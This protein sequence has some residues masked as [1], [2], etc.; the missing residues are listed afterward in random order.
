[1]AT[2]GELQDHLGTLAVILWNYGAEFPVPTLDE[3]ADTGSFGFSFSADLPGD[4]LPAP[5]MI[6]LSE[7]WVPGDLARGLDRTEY[8]YD[9]VE[10]PRNRRRAFHSTQ[11]DFYAR[12]FG[13][14]VHE[15]C[16]EILGA[17][18]CRHYFGLPVTAYEAIATFTA[19]WGQPAP[20]DCADLRCMW[21]V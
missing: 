5:A 9:F 11:R 3:Y 10:H 4:A 2:L 14:L 20:L 1:M 15:H 21:Q 8:E 6:K 17:P 16:E 7:I 12:Y 18:T 19:I 13:V